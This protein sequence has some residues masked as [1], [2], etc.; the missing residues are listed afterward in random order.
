[1]F[2]NLS[3]RITCLTLFAT[4]LLFSGCGSRINEGNYAAIETGMTEAEVEGLLGAGDEQASSGIN[5]SGQTMNIP[6][7]G[8]ISVPGMSSSGK[9]MVWKNGDRIITVMFLDNKVVSKAR[10]GF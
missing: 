6:G 4:T 7:A 1:M 9:T 10:F 3:C 2:Q 8:S 5:I